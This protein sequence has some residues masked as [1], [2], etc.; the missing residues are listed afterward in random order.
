MAMLPIAKNAVTRKPY[1]VFQYWNESRSDIL[2]VAIATKKVSNAT[3][4]S[5]SNHEIT[6]ISWS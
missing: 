3:A 6:T 2:M 5:G 1:E 4:R